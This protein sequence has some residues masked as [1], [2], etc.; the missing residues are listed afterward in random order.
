MPMNWIPLAIEEG[1]LYMLS[2]SIGPS[3]LDPSIL[4]LAFQPTS[5]PFRTTPPRHFHMETTPPQRPGA[6]AIAIAMLLSSL[7]TRDR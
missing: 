5:L 4:P 3:R 7:F 2:Q 6:I 1:P